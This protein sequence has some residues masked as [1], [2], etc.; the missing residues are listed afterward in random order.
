MEFDKSRELYR[1]G[2]LYIIFITVLGIY[3]NAFVD[4]NPSNSKL[5]TI[6]IVLWILLYFP[7][8]ICVIKAKYQVSEFGFKITKKL[9]VSL[10]IFLVIILAKTNFDI[11]T[12]T[13]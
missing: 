13:F 1:L 11:S 2:I 6:A 10:P 9:L 4:F 3:L 5:L 7:I 12:S 8:P